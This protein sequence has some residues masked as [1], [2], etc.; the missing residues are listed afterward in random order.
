MIFEVGMTVPTSFAEKKTE[1][2]QLGVQSLLEIQDL[3]LL[4]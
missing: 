2:E 3:T 4:L 1:E